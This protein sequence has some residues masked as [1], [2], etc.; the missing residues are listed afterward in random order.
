MS[1]PSLDANAKHGGLGSG[2]RK[3]EVDGFMGVSRAATAE[4]RGKWRQVGRMRARR[5]LTV[6]LGPLR[7]E[8]RI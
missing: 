1:R 7:P 3:K 5:P 6:G 8:N 2:R 4:K